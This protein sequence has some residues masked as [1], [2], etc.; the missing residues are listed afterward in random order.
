MVQPAFLTTC[1]ASPKSQKTQKTKDGH[2]LFRLVKKNQLYHD[3]QNGY[4]KK[5]LE[6]YAGFENAGNF[7]HHSLAPGEHHVTGQLVTPKHFT[8]IC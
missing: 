4:R 1:E 7:R 8:V 3:P 2:V 6:L 5:S